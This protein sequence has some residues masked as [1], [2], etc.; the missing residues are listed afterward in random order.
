MAADPQEVQIDKEKREHAELASKWLAEIERRRGKESKWRE[1]ARRVIE[2]Y[3]DER[4]LDDGMTKYN[5]LYANTEVIKPAIF[6]RMPVPDVRRRWMTKDPPARTAALILE[7]ALSF[8][9]SAYDFKDVLDRSLEDYVL[10]GRGEA[11]V[12]YDPLFLTRQVKKPVSPLPPG[13]PDET[14]ET[15]GQEAAETKP[16]EAPEGPVTGEDGQM[17]PPG[18]Q[19]DPAVGP[20]QMQPEQYKAW[21]TVYTRYV[22]WDLFGFSDCTQWSEVPAVW[23]GQYARKDEVRDI[24]PDFK[25]IDSLNF[26]PEKVGSD[27]NSDYSKQPQNTILLWRV[28]HKAARKYMVFAHGY[29]DGP[30]VVQDDPTQLENFYPMPEPLY[31]IRTNGDWCPKPEYVLY[32]DQAIEL[33]NVANRL[34]NL[35]QALKYRGVYDAAF[36]A[37][38]SQK[39]SDL[40]KKPDN[41]FFPIPNFRELAEKGGIEAIISALPL[42]EIAK[43][44]EKLSVR[45]DQLE[46]MIYQIYGIADI[47]RGASEA[48]ETLGAQQLKAQYGGLRI[49]TRQQR[50]Q[51]Y[52]RD[53][54]RIKAEIIAEHFSPDTLRLMCGLDVIP[55]AQFQTLKQSDSLPAGAVSQSEFDQAIQI[56]RSDKLRGFKVDIETDS[57]VPV[58]RMQDQTNRVQFMQ[59]VG[60]YLQ[61]VIPAVEQG[62]IPAKVAREGLLFV[63]RG[64][65]VGTELEEVLEEIGDDGDQA[66]E[67]AKL[68]QTLAQMQQQM[69]QLQQENQDLKSRKEENVVRAQ[70][71]IAVA[72]RQAQNDIAVDNAQAQNSMALQQ[73]KTFA[74]IGIDAAK[75][76]NA[77]PP[78]SVQ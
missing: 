27:H 22:P 66:Q 74:Q 20:Y 17:Y 9:M 34:T 65:K 16:V 12:C 30:L 50:F 75:A 1:K 43:V 70:A 62:A 31:S 38:G 3:R 61:G 48:S 54:L 10:P 19:F 11:F 2:R 67:L 63:V 15:E 60:Q 57:T 41:T 59:A 26:A 13:D 45:K 7:R 52:I 49:S 39:L 44:I 23:F 53:I 14:S 72:D 33:D 36:D 32:Q 25:D 42:E 73:Q 4:D 76:K 55:D 5:I 28:W 37:D 40:T 8:C 24:A 68:K 51:H 35:T 46:S 69:A 71:D 58:D 77:P 18:T 78:S 64:F 6:S 56:I 47:M 29:T 21:E